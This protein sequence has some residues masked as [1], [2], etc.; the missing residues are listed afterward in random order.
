M[1]KKGLI[2]MQMKTTVGSQIT[3]VQ[4]VQQFSAAKVE[5]QALYAHKH[6]DKQQR[7]EG[8]TRTPGGGGG[9]ITGP[10]WYA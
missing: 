5:L 7:T 10:I 2:A 6:P 4:N 3:T 8:P 1:F 9:Q